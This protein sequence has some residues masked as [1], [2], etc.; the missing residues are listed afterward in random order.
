[1]CS[2]AYHSPTSVSHSL[3]EISLAVDS[4]LSGVALVHQKIPAV[5]AAQAFRVP[6]LVQH[7]EDEAVHDGRLA[8][9]AHWDGI[10]SRTSITNRFIAL[11][12]IHEMGVITH[13]PSNTLPHTTTTV[14]TD[15]QNCLHIN[16]GLR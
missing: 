3:G 6:G 12:N 15:S 4:S 5:H 11:C 8:T 14:L 9:R 1:M 10:W 13:A 2:S 7:F 16:K